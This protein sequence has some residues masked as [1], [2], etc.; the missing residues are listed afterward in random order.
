MSIRIVIA[1]DHSSV[2]HRLMTFL[3]LTQNSMTVNIET[4]PLRANNET[5]IT[6]LYT[7]KTYT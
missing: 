5:F 4:P 2:H 3:A 6:A 1:A 7:P